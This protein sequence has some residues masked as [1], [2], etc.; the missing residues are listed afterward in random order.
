VGIFCTT[1][2]NCRLGLI[3]DAS[4]CKVPVT[5]RPPSQV[6]TTAAPQLC[7]A[8][9]RVAI[10]RLSCGFPQLSDTTSPPTNAQF[11]PSTQTSP[12]WYGCRDSGLGRIPLYSWIKTTYG[13]RLYTGSS[14]IC[15]DRIFSSTNAYPD[16]FPADDFR[17]TSPFGGYTLENNGDPICYIYQNN[18]NNLLLPLYRFELSSSDSDNGQYHTTDT[19]SQ[20]IFTIWLGR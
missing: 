3:C 8:D 4:T 17:R 9:Q 16:I 6:S 14:A 15:P 13:K 11:Y 7:P 5:T 12:I 19:Q 18:I 10:Y 1:N 20:T 2:E